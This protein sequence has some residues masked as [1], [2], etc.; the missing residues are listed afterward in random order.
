MSTEITPAVAHS[1]FQSI[2]KAADRLKGITTGKHSREAKAMLEGLLVEV[3]AAINQA[4]GMPEVS[5]IM[6]R[7][8]PIQ[9]EGRLVQYHQD[10][11]D[12]REGVPDWQKDSSGAFLN[13]ELR[14]YDDSPLPDAPEGQFAPAAV[15]MWLGTINESIPQGPTPEE[16]ERWHAPLYAML[17]KR[18][19]VTVEVLDA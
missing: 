2:A 15:R 13:A 9:T 4:Q 5:G 10:S 8:F 6:S 16:L 12:Y 1:W 19:R 17:G 11:D 7:H 3:N 18:V 14:N